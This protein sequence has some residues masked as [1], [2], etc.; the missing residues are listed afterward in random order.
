MFFYSYR[1]ITFIWLFC[2][3]LAIFPVTKSQSRDLIENLE[4]I[5]EIREQTRR[6]NIDRDYYF[7]F[8]ARPCPFIQIFILSLSGFIQILS[9]FVAHPWYMYR[10]TLPV[11]LNEQ[12]N[13]L[14]IFMVK[15][16]TDHIYWYFSRLKLFSTLYYRIDSEI[17]STHEMYNVHT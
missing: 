15:I 13:F 6:F 12:V 16:F 14:N 8:Q 9:W 3:I 4:N 2:V 1:T 17:I 11:R 7:D 10:R 5:I